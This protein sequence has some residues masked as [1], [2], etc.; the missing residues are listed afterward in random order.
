MIWW[1]R[2]IFVYCCFGSNLQCDCI[3]IV[4]VVICPFVMWFG[5]GS[6][7]LYSLFVLFFAIA[8]VSIIL[9][10]KYLNCGVVAAH[11]FETAII[12]TCRKSYV[13]IFIILRF[14]LTHKT[15]ATSQ[16]KEMRSIVG[17]VQWCDNCM[18]CTILCV[19]TCKLYCWL[20]PIALCIHLLRLRSIA[21]LFVL[22]AHA[23]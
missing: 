9:S 1:R 6:P 7:F 8:T 11:V 13:L 4:C 16:S 23:L 18:Y 19:R 15:S 14:L 21:C 10:Y 20:L 2:D 22:L 5:S 3:I 17:P 12:R